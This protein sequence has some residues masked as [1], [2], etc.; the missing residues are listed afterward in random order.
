MLQKY[1]GSTDFELQVPYS[2]MNAK[3]QLEKHLGGTE[4]YP[5]NG[6]FDGTS[7]HLKCNGYERIKIDITLK[8]EPIN[9]DLSYIHITIIPP[10]QYK[11]VPI[12]L[13]VFI[14]LLFVT[15]HWN[16][17]STLGFS[18]YIPYILITFIGIGVFWNNYNNIQKR[19]IGLFEKIFNAG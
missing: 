18:A 6:T 7:Y 1:F 19:I 14:L 16:E 2:A 17:I 12:I 11:Y 9:E 5:F 15:S 10:N 8:I 4:N 13:P 3:A